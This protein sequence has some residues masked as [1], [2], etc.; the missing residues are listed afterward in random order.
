MP[1]STANAASV[2]TIKAAQPWIPQKPRK[3]TPRPACG[4]PGQV[5]DLT[6]PPTGEQNQKKRTFDVLPKPANLISSRQHRPA[7]SHG[8]KSPGRPTG[9]HSLLPEAVP[10]SSPIGTTGAFYQT[11]KPA[12]PGSA[13]RP[14]PTPIARATPPVRLQHATPRI[15][16]LS[17]GDGGRRWRRLS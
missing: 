17:S 15:S 9:S 2:V 3:S 8:T 16:P 7:K 6:T 1:T 14:R 12:A 11:E 4:R 5:C 13:P 10:S